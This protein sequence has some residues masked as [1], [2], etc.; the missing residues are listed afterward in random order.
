MLQLYLDGPEDKFTEFVYAESDLPQEVQ[1]ILKGVKN[2]YSVRKLPFVELC[3]E[4]ITEKSLGYFMQFK[5]METMF[6][7]KLLGVNAF[8]QPAVEEYKDYTNKYLQ[9]KMQGWI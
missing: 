3:L 7:G 8:D 4:G 9:N 5:M 2:S 6:L 1:A